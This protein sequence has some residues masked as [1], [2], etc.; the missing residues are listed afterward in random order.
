M[1]NLEMTRFFLNVVDGQHHLAVASC[2]FG[3]W[4]YL[5]TCQPKDYA[6]DQ[7]WLSSD[8]C[9][10]ISS[11]TTRVSKISRFITL[12]FFCSFTQFAAVHLSIYVFKC[13]YRE[14]SQTCRIKSISRPTLS[15][16]KC[17]ATNDY[18]AKN[19]HVRINAHGINTGKLISTE[20][21]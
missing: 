4:T 3:V 18:I 19:S 9:R 12:R 17:T 10:Q 1:F 20:Y 21:C 5:I 13:L 6:N 16:S 14:T 15:H 8:P 11:Y 7:R 2:E